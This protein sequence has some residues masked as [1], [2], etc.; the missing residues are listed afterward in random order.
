MATIS[1][2]LDIAR[3]HLAAKQY[4]SAEQV[5]AMIVEVEP[6]ADA[7]WHIGGQAASL[8]GCYEA[9]EKK[10]G[11][12]IALR[13]D[14]G[15]Y[16]RCLGNVLA[17]Q[18]KLAEA[19][20]CFRQALAFNPGDLETE[21][22]LHRAVARVPYP[23][24]IPPVSVQ[25]GLDFLLLNLPPSDGMLPYGLAFVHNAVA[26]AGVRL[27]TVDLNL[28]VF[29]RYHQRL[30]LGRSW[31]PGPNGHALKKSLWV[32]DDYTGWESDEVL[33]Y[34]WAADI[35]DVLNQ[36]ARNRPK[37]VAFA[38]H[39]NNRTLAKRFV[40]ELRHLAPGV[41]VIVGGFDCAH[42]ETGPLLFPDFDYMAIS[43]AD[44]TIG[45]LAAA[46]ARGERPK[47]LAGVLSR[48]DTPG[49]AWEDAPLVQN[50]DSL[51]FPRYQWT[52]PSLYRAFYTSPPHAMPISTSR[53]CNWGRCRFCQECF[54]YRCR[55]PI[56]VVDEIEEWIYKGA[57]R[58]YFFES[59]VNGNADVLYGLCT[60]VVR[61]DLRVSLCGQ[62]RVDKRC[63]TEYF[64]HLNRAGFIRLR[65]GVDG[66]S[67]HTLQL[68]HKGYNMALVMQN[69]RDCHKAGIQ[70]EVNLVVGVPGETDQDVDEAIANLVRCKPYIASV[71][72]INPLILGLASEYFRNAEQY[73]IRFRADRDTIFREHGD[74]V[75]ADLWYSENPYIDHA[76]RLTR[77]NRICA[78]LKDNGV[79]IGPPAARLVE[80]LQLPNAMLD[81]AG[82]VRLR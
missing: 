6:N 59:E 75:P 36:I 11:R 3:Q 47:D 62:M 15:E 39:A 45:P 61:R 76:V 8:V 78:G 63:T 23:L 73:K 50:L 58:F 77:L 70:T 68:Q 43:E 31:L 51:E 82:R 7:A 57:M 21:Q 27:Q 56:K 46:I 37:A 25:V 81:G 10:I 60:E 66:W 38:V 19:E 32:A 54:P 29:H 4:A 17:A 79:T 20:A 24:Y 41:L 49:R 44:L 35:G 67:D 18:G 69:L 33:E 2:A 42:P 26:K 74:Y 12:A 52:E 65:F 55:S 28:V 80:K 30:C 13:P 5:C 40:R 14:C 64:Q 9:A 71:E 1:E 48:F 16:Y 22:S 72:Y 34:V 53:G